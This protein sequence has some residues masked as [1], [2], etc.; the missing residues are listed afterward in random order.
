VGEV[1]GAGRL[2]ALAALPRFGTFFASAMHLLRSCGDVTVSHDAAF[3]A[4]V[5]AALSGPAIP[6]LFESLLGLPAGNWLG[7]PGLVCAAVA[8]ADDGAPGTAAPEVDCDD[9]NVFARVRATPV[10]R[11]GSFMVSTRSGEP[12]KGR[13]PKAAM[14]VPSLPMTHKTSDGRCRFCACR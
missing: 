13:S 14:R 9:A 3:G 12:S 8:A 11:T 6:I 1:Y 10:I 2:A 4:V 5:S 7:T